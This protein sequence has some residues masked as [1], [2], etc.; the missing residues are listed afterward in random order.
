MADQPL[1]RIVDDDAEILHSQ[2]LL[3]ETLGWEVVAYSSGVDFLRHD[4]LRRPGCVVLDVRMP[5]MTGLEVQEE[6]EKRGAAHIAV[7]FLS[8]H[9]DMPMAVHTMKHGAADFL[10]K[11]AD[12]R[13]LLER[14]SACVARS[15]AKSD[16]EAELRRLREL[17]AALSPRE[18]DVA[19]CIAR[20]L[21]NKEI[22]RELGIE[23]TTVKMHRSNA[24]LKLQARTS[25]D[26]VR[27]F[28]L[29]NMKDKEASL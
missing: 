9:G 19:R 17:Y 7:I 25:A 29:L 4:A 8:A 11:P 10:Q 2:K 18:R 26:L 22:A 3:L 5:D 12:P 15:V 28:T 27:I 23:E 21:R 13:Y 20:G 6:M 16:L 14:V 24:L 1:V